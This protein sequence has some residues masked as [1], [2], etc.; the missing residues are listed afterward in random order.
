MLDGDDGND[1][2]DGGSGANT[3]RGGAG[4]DAL[5]AGGGD[6]TLEGGA[7][8]DIL[9]AGAG[10]NTVSG[11]EGDDTLSSFSGTD[12]LEGGAG[13]D[14]YLVSFLD[15]I[16]E[17]AGG[18]VD[19]V[20]AGIGWTLAAEVENLTLTGSAAIDGTGN[21]AANVLVGNDQ[22]NV[23]KG[24]DNDDRIEGEAGADTLDGGVGADTMIG[25]AGGDTYYV[26][27]VGD[28]AI[29]LITGAVDDGAFDVV[30]S[31]VGLRLAAKSRRCGC[32]TAAARPLSRAT[33]LRTRSALPTVRTS[34]A[35]WVAPTRLTGAAART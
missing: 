18:G 23:L 9:E 25:G 15:R 34:C 13:N 2:L 26:D 3:L 16:V 31:T 6:D 12:V 19:T 7:G 8:D 11:G 10:S 14:A 35:A 4:D 1:V 20:R 17:A 22:A 21:A 30:Y 28:L 29:E 27:D 24:L 32:S 33:A 5:Q